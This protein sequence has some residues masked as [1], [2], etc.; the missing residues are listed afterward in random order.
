M[1]ESEIT[2]SLSANKKLTIQADDFRI[3]RQ[4]GAIAKV[5][6]LTTPSFTGEVG[7]RG[8]ICA[9]RELYK[10]KSVGANR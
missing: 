5:A 4:P 3:A 6:R 8:R 9:R 2:L 10:R 1:A 7:S